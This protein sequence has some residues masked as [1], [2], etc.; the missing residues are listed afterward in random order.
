MPT[1]KQYTRK[2]VKAAHPVVCFGDSLTQA[3][4][5]ADYLGYLSEEF[6]PQGY[7]FINAGVSGDTS[8]MVLQRM[9]DVVACQPEIVIVACGAN[10]AA[11]YI[12]PAWMMSYLKG[13]KSPLI[14]T[15]ERF[16]ENMATIFGRLQRETDATLAALELPLFTEDLQG[17]INARVQRY[18]AILHE[19]AA[20]AG[21]P[22]I[23][24]YEPMAALIPP[25]FTP[26]EWDLGRNMMSKA[27][28]QR[29]LLRRTWD[30]IGERNGLLLHSDQAHMNTK[31]ARLIANQ[32][33]AWLRTQV[34]PA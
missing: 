18:N 2:G 12:S 3:V 14:P 16:A 10:D 8:Y 32:I 11:A 20:E 13:G 28:Y 4:L 17:E 5:S 6:G 23:P 25:D 22:V 30:E 24:L 7:E 19:V 27:L 15:A 34:P 26:P 1:P 9:E 31:G 21:V 29:Y 33:A